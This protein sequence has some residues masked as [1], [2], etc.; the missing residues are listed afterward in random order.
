MEKILLH[1]YPIPVKKLEFGA[2]TATIIDVQLI[3][4][5]AVG[6]N[7]FKLVQD[8]GREIHTITKTTHPD[9]NSGGFLTGLVRIF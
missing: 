3:S 9:S 4:M 5:A 1:F 7:V 2:H 6:I 8:V